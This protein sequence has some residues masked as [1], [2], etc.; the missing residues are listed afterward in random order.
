ME[1]TVE[2]LDLIDLPVIDEKVRR[3][4]FLREWIAAYRNHDVLMP[5]SM[6]AHV[7]AVSRQRVHQLIEKDQLASVRV[8]DRVMVPVA[9]IEAYLATD[10][11]NGRPPSMSESFRVAVKN[12]RK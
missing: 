5:P 12:S 6:V 2:Q 1:A 3:K 11:P 4:S 8:C 9:A 7:L 10:R